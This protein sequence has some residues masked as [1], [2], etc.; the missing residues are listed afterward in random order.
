MERRAEVRGQ[1]S[2]VGGKK[3]KRIDEWMVAWLDDN[4]WDKNYAGMLDLWNS[5]SDVRKAE[6]HG[7]KIKEL[8][9]G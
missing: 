9:I 6:F 5:P 4:C 2:E 1:R 7:V 3:G 8:R